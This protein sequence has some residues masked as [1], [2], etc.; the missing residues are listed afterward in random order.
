MST[1]ILQLNKTNIITYKNT[2][3]YCDST[4]NSCSNSINK[5]KMQI[6]HIDKIN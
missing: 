4:K 6:W 1:S 5:D 2:T 3:S